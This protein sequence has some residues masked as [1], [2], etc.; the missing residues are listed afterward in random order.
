MGCVVKLLIVLINVAGDA[1]IQGEKKKNSDEKIR[2]VYHKLLQE[3]FLSEN[4]I[5]LFAVKYSEKFIAIFP[6][7]YNIMV[8]SFLEIRNTFLY[9]FNIFTLMCQKNMLAIHPNR[10][11]MILRS[12]GS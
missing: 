12:K 3:H 5:F 2:I 1:G 4:D 10:N 11:K 9:L 8:R 6:P 7:H